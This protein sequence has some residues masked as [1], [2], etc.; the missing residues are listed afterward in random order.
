[1]N[2]EPPPVDSSA[3]SE[4]ALLHHLLQNIP[5][6]IYFKDLQ[7]RFVRISPAM[8]A[9]FGL[10]D[11]AEAVGLTDF[12]I[13][14]PEH[15]REALADEEEIMRTGK[16]VIGKV[17]RVTLPDG[18]EAWALST[19]MPLR[20]S[21]GRIIG[22]F[23][24][25][26]DY[27]ELKRAQDQVEEAHEALKQSYEDLKQTQ[28]QLIE[29]EKM[30]SIGRLAAGLAHE[31]NNPLAMIKMGV[32]FLKMMPELQKDDDLP[33]ILSGIVEGIDRADEMIKRLIAFAAP[34]G[35]TL[36][37]ESMNVLVERALELLGHDL[38]ES[39]AT[40]EQELD[41][42]LPEVPLDRD[43]ITQVLIH[44]LTNALHATRD[45]G[46]VT[47]RTRTERRGDGAGDAGL[48]HGKQLRAGDLIVVT[49]VQDTGSGIP[50]ENLARIFDPFFTTKPTGQGV[51]LGLTVCRKIIEL[52]HGSLLVENRPEGGV[53]ATIQLKSEPEP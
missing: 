19:K 25:T 16:P 52:H 42:K 15:A 38:S 27:T 30:S 33:S 39:R 13:H 44:L 53:R 43:K 31:I 48:R 12:D 36:E 34:R 37:K 5:D 1:M 17:E 18:S 23:G 6:R 47:I 51:G 28:L 24:I 3:Y 9:R 8:A 11:P 49:E 26:R 40:V 21:D 50:E 10:E 20:D 7:S 2:P 22:T 14:D 41:E 35:L 46:T 4:A 32:D 29:A 45:G